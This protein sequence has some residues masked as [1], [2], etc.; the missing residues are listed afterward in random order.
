M[1]SSSQEQLTT[2]KAVSVITF[3][4]SI[5]GGLNY[6][7]VPEGDLAHTP[8]S[9]SNLLLFIYWGIMYVWQLIYI[10]QAFFSLD[11]YRSSV[12]Q[13]VGWHFPVFNVLAYIWFEFFT[14][15]HYFLSELTLIINFI[16]TL[17]L[18]FGHKTFAVK[19]LTNW[20]L[21]HVPLVALTMSWLL[22]AIFWNG[23]IWLHIHKTWGRIVANIFIWNFLLVPGFF[24][25][26]FNDWATGLSFSFLMFALG[27]GQL[28]TKVF[29]LQ[30]IFAFVIAGILLLW[31]FIAMIVGAP[32]QI[33]DVEQAPLLVV[34]EERT[35]TS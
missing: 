6:V 22:Y 24:L 32:K 35:T 15:G 13:L 3:L 31:S 4:L 5:Y 28:G 17:I 20:L 34:E 30:W 7:G 29:A 2:Y 9:G 27:F 16:N 14:R 26:L 33:I 21:I 19:P 1:A 23:A 10:I 11:E 12:I 18:Y 8:Y 25:L